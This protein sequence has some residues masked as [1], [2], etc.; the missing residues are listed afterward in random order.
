MNQ[1]IQQNAGAA[2]EMS[3]TA[4][5]LASQA[6]QLLDTVSYFQIN[7]GKRA[8]ASH[9]QSAQ[10]T[11]IVE[12]GPA[13]K[14]HSIVQLPAR[15]KKAARPVAVSRLAQVNGVSLRMDDGSTKGNGDGKDCDFE[16]Y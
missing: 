12:G 7:D 5:E 3:S 9:R 8:A 6:E 15:E 16:R 14:V 2:E 13:S 1:V 4:E 10:L 11:K